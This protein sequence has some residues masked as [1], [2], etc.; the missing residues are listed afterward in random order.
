N[1]QARYLLVYSSARQ[2]SGKT[3]WEQSPA[4]LST[5]TAASLKMGS[6]GSFSIPHGPDGSLWIGMMNAPY[7]KAVE[8]AVCGKTPTR[9]GLLNELPLPWS[10]KTGG[11]S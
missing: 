2:Q 4:S 10:G 3:Y 8:S 7:K 5:T 11:S 6:T 9:D 1:K